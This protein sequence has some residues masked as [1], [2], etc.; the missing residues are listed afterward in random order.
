MMGRLERLGMM[1]RITAIWLL[2]LFLMLSAAPAISQ[3]Q[4]LVLDKIS[5]LP[6]LNSTPTCISKLTSLAVQ[7]SLEIANLEER[8][9]LANQTIS[10][11]KSKLWTSWLNPNPV[12]VVQNLLGGGDRQTAELRIAQLQL[13]ESELI[14]R[15][16]QL[17]EDLG[18]ELTLLVQEYERTVNQL[19]LAQSE[20]HLHS[21]R[22]SVMDLSYRQG[23]G[24]TTQMIGLWQQTDELAVK[25]SELE[26]RRSQVVRLVESLCGF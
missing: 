8:L 19:K 25:I 16:S 1:G 22:L 11:Q 9:A 26:N 13:N 6:C 2:Q 15:R 23:N 21:T 24:S 18:R 4:P 14:R 7:N 17:E 12:A 3:E 5:G 10:H 20:A